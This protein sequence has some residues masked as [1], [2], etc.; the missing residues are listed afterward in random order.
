MAAALLFTQTRGAWLGTAAGA[1]VLIW[2]RDRRLLGLL[3][4]MAAAALILAPGPVRD[5]LHGLT[6][7]TDVTANERIYLWKSALAM[8]RDHPWT[9]V[10]PGNVEDA[11][12]VY[13]LPDDP[14]LDTNPWYHMHSNIFQILAE[15]GIPGLLAWTWIWIAWFGAAYRARQPGPG[16]RPS[17]YWVAG[18][19]ATVAFLVAGLTECAYGDSELAYRAYFLMALPLSGSRPEGP[20]AT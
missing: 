9:G 20:P 10:G 12:R 1:V 4:V 16:G 8:A 6:D 18:V 15:R 17:W 11:W 2:Y 7:L 19:A 5:R 3:P 13:R 14:W